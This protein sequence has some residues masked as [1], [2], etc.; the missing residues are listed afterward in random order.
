[1]DE[2]SFVT[3]ILRLFNPESLNDLKLTLDRL[4]WKVLK[5]I[6]SLLTSFGIFYS[7]HCMISN[8]LCVHFSPKLPPKMQNLNND[9]MYNNHLLQLMEKTRDIILPALFDSTVK[10][11]E[12]LKGKLS[13]SS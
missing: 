10:G 7:D 1:M 13:I 12:F 2:S 11:T 6:P 8:G 4:Y 9:D 3:G 5:K